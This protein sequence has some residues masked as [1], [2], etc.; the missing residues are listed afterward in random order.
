M[1]AQ[2]DIGSTR[3]AGGGRRQT[4]RDVS[5]APSQAT[6]NE[7]DDEEAEEETP[8]Q[9]AKRVN[10]KAARARRQ[11]AEETE[12]DNDVESVLDDDSDVI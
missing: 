6:V 8:R 4:S 1:D 11:Q 3:R 12:S 5:E 7:S 2:S 10:G 9:P